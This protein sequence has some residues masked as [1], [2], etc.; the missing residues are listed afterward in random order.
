MR[1]S[2]QIAS[3]PKPAAMAMDI[4]KK[5][6]PFGE[7]PPNG[8]QTSNG[9]R[10]KI[11]TWIHWLVMRRRTRPSRDPAVTPIAHTGIRLYMK[12]TRAQPPVTGLQAT[13]R[14]SD[15]PP[16]RRQRGLRLRSLPGLSIR[17]AGYSATQA[18]P[19]RTRTHPPNC[20]RS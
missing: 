18:P 4:E 2:F 3:R 14:K 8:A 11:A 15:A 5:I 10:K 9:A 20:H 13:G 17:I 16:R 7:S 19:V 12:K 1:T 6:A